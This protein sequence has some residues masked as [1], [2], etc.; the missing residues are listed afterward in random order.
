MRN[1]LRQDSNAL[2]D[3]F[4]TRY[5]FVGKFILSESHYE[6]RPLRLK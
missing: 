2:A 3:F 1:P 5:I 4:I 6:L